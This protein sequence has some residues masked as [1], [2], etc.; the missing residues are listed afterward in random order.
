MSY[1]SW[2]ILTRKDDPGQQARHEKG[3]DADFHGGETNDFAK[4]KQI[5]RQI[6]NPVNNFP[7]RVLSRSVESRPGGPGP[8]PG[9]RFGSRPGV[10]IRLASKLAAKPVLATASPVAIA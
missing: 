5:L 2:A 8:R 9:G 10:A 4:D 6:G 7:R 3:L 1:P